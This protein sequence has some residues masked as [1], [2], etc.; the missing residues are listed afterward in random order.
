MWAYINEKKDI[1]EETSKPMVAIVINFNL[2]FFWVTKNWK[3]AK[4][5]DNQSEKFPK[6]GTIN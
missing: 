6:E 5:K 1:I 2:L 4:N 3:K